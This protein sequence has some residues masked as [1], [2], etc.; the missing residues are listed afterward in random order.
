MNKL[1][2][3]LLRK[4]A[5]ATVALDAHRFLELQHQG[6]VEVGRHTYGRPDVI[7]YAG[8][9]ARVRIGSFCSISPG[10][11][12]MT[13]GIHPTNWVSLFPF[14]I[15]WNME[16]A[17]RDGMPATRGD[18]VIGSDV[19]IGTGALILS[20]VTIGHGS[21]IGAHS[22]VTRD[23]PPYA[24]AAGMPARVVGHRFSEEVI[25]RLLELAWWTWPDETIREAIPLLSSPKVEEFLLEYSLGQGDRNGRRAKLNVDRP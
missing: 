5:N 10:V 22:V 1:K 21:V 11:Q 23:I 17:Y 3:W 8:S 25:G 16:G 4:L 24:I 13:G 14:R 6:L 18:V 15:R 20:G 9:E 19:W 12:I 2:K 7:N